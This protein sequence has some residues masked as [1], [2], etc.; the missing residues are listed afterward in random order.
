MSYNYSQTILQSPFTR[1]CTLLKF[2][3]RYRA[4]KY[5]LIF[6]SGTSVFYP[7]CYNLFPPFTIYSQ[8]IEPFF[9]FAR[10]LHFRISLTPR[11][12]GGF[13]LDG[14]LPIPSVVFLTIFRI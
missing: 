3:Q 2:S 6:Q 10:P 7:F 5:L 1:K 13:R 8:F 9:Y 12:F 11:V 14:L 4:T